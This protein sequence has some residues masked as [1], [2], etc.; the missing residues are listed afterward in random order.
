MTH[1]R[2]RT[3]LAFAL[4]IP[5]GLILNAHPVGAGTEAERADGGLYLV[6]IHSDWCGTC[7][8]MEPLWTRLGEEC[9]DKAQLVLLDVTDRESTENSSR[10]A[11]RLGLKEFFDAHKSKTA[12]IAVIE[13][14]T[15][16]PVAVFKG[17]MD[18]AKYEA[19]LTEGRGECGA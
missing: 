13:A 11:E 5:L 19:V 2:V 16:K 10:E 6:K 3:A 8:R 9:G 15:G 1:L 17:E 4:A 18:F 7:T 14:A 12:T